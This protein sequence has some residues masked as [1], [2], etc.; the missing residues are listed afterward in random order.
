M[1]E[2][3]PPHQPAGVTLRAAEESDLPIFFEY[4]LDPAANAMAAFAARDWD[5][6]ASHWTSI[7]ADETVVAQTILLDGQ[8]VG[9]IVSFVYQGEREVGYWVDRRHWGKG[10]ATQALAAFLDIE[11]H[12]PLHAGVAQHNPGSI[13][14]LEKCGFKVV[15]ETSWPADTPGE[16][17][18]QAVLL[19]LEA[20]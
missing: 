20:G 12:R 9:N 13:R 6:H 16:V 5:D 8:V 19:L 7:L 14:V 11:T 2:S 10:V 18:V 1:D 15:G 4:Q 3:K 17:D